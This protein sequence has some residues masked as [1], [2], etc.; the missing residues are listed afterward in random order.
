M[1]WYI[2]SQ[3]TAKTKEGRPCQRRARPWVTRCVTHLTEA[4]K[5]VENQARLDRLAAAAEAAAETAD[6]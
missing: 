3:C 6:E 2:Y 1:T 4:D 5:E